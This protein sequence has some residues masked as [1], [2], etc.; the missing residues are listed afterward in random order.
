M[1]LELNYMKK[2]LLIFTIF[3]LTFSLSACFFSK[4]KPD[5][6]AEVIDGVPETGRVLDISEMNDQT[7][8]VTPGDVL[9][10]KLTGE[11]DSGYQWSVTGPTSGDYLM[12]KDHKV[13][14]LTDP[15]AGTFT[16]EWWLK[17]EEPGIFDLQFEYGLPSQEPEE[18]FRFKVISQ[19]KD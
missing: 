11:A 4:D 16:D 6:I 14:G 10:F 19:D 3:L 2:I 18:F 17:I 12:L 1:K 13:V 5:E 15:E 8:T 9:Y 7:A